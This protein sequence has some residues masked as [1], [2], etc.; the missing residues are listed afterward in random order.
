M[1]RAFLLAIFIATAQAG[2]YQN[3]IVSGFAPDPSVCRVGGDFYLA[4]S[5]FTMFPSLPVYHSK[6]LVNWKLI[7]YGGTRDEQ[8]PLKGRGFNSGVWAPTIRHHDGTFYLVV[9]N[10]AAREH[11]LLKSKDP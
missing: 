4:N 6:D 1:I 11:I 7:G 8:T 10:Q 3:P 9:K 2:T 5:S